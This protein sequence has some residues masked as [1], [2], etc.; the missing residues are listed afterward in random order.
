MSSQTEEH[1]KIYGREVSNPVTGLERPR[2]FQEF[3]VPRFHDN[4][5]ELW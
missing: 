5:T 3:K 4:G 1:N 2:G